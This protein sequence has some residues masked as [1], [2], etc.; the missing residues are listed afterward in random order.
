MIS[1]K[2]G[3]LGKLLVQSYQQPFAELLIL[4]E[5]LNL[6]EKLA[7]PFTNQIRLRGQKPR[8]LPENPK[9]TKLLKLEK[10]IMPFLNQ[11]QIRL[12]IILKLELLKFELLGKTQRLPVK[13]FLLTKLKL[14]LLTLTMPKL[15]NQK[16]YRRDATGVAWLGGMT[17]RRRKLGMMGAATRSTRPDHPSAD[18]PEGK[19]E[20]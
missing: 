12:A 10:L 13:L 9:V 19:P 2:L 5:R 7:L 15:P 17:E 3:R 16:K 20:R 6:L 14:L 18:I 8:N 1:G 11:I 4:L